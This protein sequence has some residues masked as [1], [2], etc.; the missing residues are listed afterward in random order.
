MNHETAWIGEGGVLDD[1]GNLIVT[2]YVDL[3]DKGSRG[4]VPAL[5]KG[6]RREHA[7]EYGDTV[8]LSKPMRFRKF[9]EALI[10]DE[11][12]GLAREESVTVLRAT[13]AETARRRAVADRNE[14]LELVNS[15]IRITETETR[16]R[17]RTNTRSYAYGDDWWIYC[18]SIKPTTDEEWAA[19]KSTLSKEYDYVSKI[20]QPAKFA[21]AL[22]RMVTEQR[23]ALTGDG[24][25][26]DTTSGFEGLQT[27]HRQQ[28][29]IHGPVVYRDNVYQTLAQT[30]DQRAW[31]AACI[32]TKAQKYADQREYRFAVF[33]GG[34]D[35]ET[36][37][38]HISGMMKDALKG[39]EGGLARAFPTAEGTGG[40]ETNRRQRETKDQITR[41][42]QS[43]KVTQR[44]TQRQERRSEIRGPDGQ[45]ESSE[46]VRGEE[47]EERIV[48][49]IEEREGDGFPA[50]SWMDREE[51]TAT[52]QNL[53]A[54][55]LPASRERTEEQPEYYEVLRELARAE[56]EAHE[57]DWRDQDGPGT[58]DGLFER[59]HKYAQR[60]LE[61]P[62]TPMSPIAKSCTE[63]ACSPEEVARIFGSIDALDLKIAKIATDQRQD[64][65]SACWYATHCIR[66]IHARLGDIVDT[67]WIERERFVVIRLKESE[68][69][70]AKGRIVVAPSGSY[71]Y[72][73]R[74][75]DSESFG[76]GGV[77]S[78]T[79]FFLMG[80]D[81]KTFEAF[82]WPAKTG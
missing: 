76:Y 18:A 36:I 37:S 78:G 55:E 40:K 22:A 73:L 12:E 70:Q 41:L 39:M 42:R 82:G 45:V 11:Q 50:E 46:S 63:V 72:F 19:W 8:L 74:L 9:G 15:R 17:R 7:L 75:P 67:L 64:A 54:E 14:A 23:G 30:N 21:Q 51:N 43:N 10:Q 69:L 38:L 53:P 2:L 32:F 56:C 60:T 35:E 27:S 44:Q 62:A 5:V 1:S 34:S 29:V 49:Q 3:R 25:M 24:W 71:A 13:P 66:N 65:A 59:L 4:T 58:I 47:I 6:C 57:D 16:E 79:T 28:T 80:G 61:D 26:R 68:N 52:A 48:E 31:I 81:I 33:N 20:G 77:E